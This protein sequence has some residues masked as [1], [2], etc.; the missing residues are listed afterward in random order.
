MDTFNVDRAMAPLSS[1]EVLFGEP[2]FRRRTT[3][4]WAAQA[5]RNHGAPLYLGS[6]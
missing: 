2:S 1:M 5:V 6:N 4:D 3:L